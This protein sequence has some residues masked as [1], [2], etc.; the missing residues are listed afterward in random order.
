MLQDGTADFDDEENARTAA[1]HLG[2]HLGPTLA[3]LWGSSDASDASSSWITL[4]NVSEAPA[5]LT[6][7]EAAAR[8]WPGRGELRRMLDQS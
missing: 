6:E 4:W 2:Q 8:A 3:R 5:M 1:P 7:G